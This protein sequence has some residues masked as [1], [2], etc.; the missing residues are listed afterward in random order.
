MLVLSLA[1][2]SKA[3][4]LE[5]YILV[6]LVFRAREEKKKKEK[7]NKAKQLQLRP[8]VNILHMISNGKKNPKIHENEKHG[9]GQGG[10]GEKLDWDLG[11]KNQILEFVVVVIQLLSH[12]WLFAIP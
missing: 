3:F 10:E 2:A 8:W 4:D 6:F 9:A 1:L 12:V 7:A 11:E 5:I